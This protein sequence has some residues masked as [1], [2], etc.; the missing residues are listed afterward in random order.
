M[1]TKFCIICLL[2][3]IFHQCNHCRKDG[4]DHGPKEEREHYHNDYQIKNES[5]FQSGGTES[6]PSKF[7]TLEESMPSKFSTLEAENEQKYYIEKIFD[8][9]GE[10][11]RLSFLG[12]EKLLISLGLGEVKVLM[13]NHD[14]IGHD[15]VSHLYALEVQEGKRSHSRNHPRS[16]S[17][18]ENQTMI[19]MAA[20]RNHKCDPERDTAVPSVKDD[21][22]HTHDQSRHHHHRHPRPHHHDRNGTHHSRNDSVSHSEHGEQNHEPS[23]ETNTTQDQPERKCKQKKKQ[24]KTGDATQDCAPDDD[25]AHEHNFVHK[26]HHVHDVSHLHVHHHEHSSDR[27]TSHGHQD[28]SLGNEDGHHHTSK[29]EASHNQINVRKHALISSRSHKDHSEDERDREEVSMK[30]RAGKLTFT[31][32]T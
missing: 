5:Y 13:I 25:P 20:K 30:W 19:G 17:D 4:H 26:H 12:L 6:M 16:H 29:R 14:D 10:N 28:S 15:H 9:Y 2:T 18:S 8:R 31:V 23:T 21:G 22:K 32:V 7:S 11:G 3:F 1:H 27:S 24:K